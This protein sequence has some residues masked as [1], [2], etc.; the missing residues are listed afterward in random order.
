MAT[1]GQKVATVALSHVGVQESPFDSNTDG[2]GWIDQIQAYWHLHSQPWCAMAVSAWYREAGVDDDGVINPGTA[3]MCDRAAAKG[4]W[5]ATKPVPTGAIMILCGIHTEVVVSDRG[6]GMLDCVGGN[7]NQQVM[8][9]VRALGSGWR[10][11]V[12][13]A[14]LQGQPEPVRAYG[15]DDPA[16]SPHR[17]GP[18]HDRASREATIAKLQASDRR[19]VRRIRIPGRNQYAFDLLNPTHWRF[20]PWQD[21]AVRDGEMAAYQQKTGRS[22][23]PWSQAVAAQGTGSPTSG[24]STR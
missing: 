8:R 6:N 15:F 20:G 3:T 5:L 1:N 12:P 17:Y 24:E 2:G 13:P 4:L 11:I 16:H 14:I 23:R 9:T 21:R 18:W 19:W 10:C 22:M 7:V